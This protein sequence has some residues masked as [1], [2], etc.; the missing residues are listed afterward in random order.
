MKRFRRLLCR[1]FGHPGP[2]DYG[3]WT[4]TQSIFG[5]SWTRTETCRRCGRAWIGWQ[6]WHPKEGAS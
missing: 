4:A 2:T 6:T 3:E 1:L 5:P